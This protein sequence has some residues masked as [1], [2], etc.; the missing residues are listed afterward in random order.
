MRY[1]RIIIFI[2]LLAMLCLLPNFCNALEPEEILVIA[3]GSS[4]EDIEIAKYYMRR[5]KVPAD[6][7]VVV[8]VNDNE[9]CSRLQYEKEI[10][11]PVRIY[12]E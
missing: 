5:R 3:N 2:E 11:T 9:T 12:L 8:W 1:F 6:N 10:A 4:C 7:L